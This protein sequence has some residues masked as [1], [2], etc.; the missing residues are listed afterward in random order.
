MKAEAVIAALLLGAAHQAH[1]VMVYDFVG[2]C[3]TGCIGQAHGTLAVYDKFATAP[4]YEGGLT[5]FLPYNQTG[6][7]VL[8]GFS[9]KGPKLPA[10]SGPAILTGSTNVDN[11]LATQIGASLTGWSI[12]NYVLPSG[13]GFS[14]TNATI[15]FREHRPEEVAA[16]GTLALLLTA[17]AIARRRFNPCRA[18]R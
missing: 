16:P 18:S 9:V 13:A 4:L 7:E 1:A 15:T 2:D 5:L 3:S 17:G 8:L 6:G 14:G 11:E 10:L 12:T